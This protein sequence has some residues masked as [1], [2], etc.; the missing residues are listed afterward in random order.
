MDDLGA[1]PVDVAACRIKQVFAVGADHG[2]EVGARRVD[3]IAQ[4]EGLAPG[5]VILAE[6]DIQVTLAPLGARPAIGIE[7]GVALVRGDEGVAADQG[8]GRLRIEQPGQAGG[9]RTPCAL[10]NPD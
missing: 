4:V 3:R 7:D 10:V 8:A 1:D 5:A 6:A 2:A 9:G